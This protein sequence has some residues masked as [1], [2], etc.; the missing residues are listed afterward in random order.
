MPRTITQRVLRSRSLRGAVLL[1]PLLLLL[2]WIGGTEFNAYHVTRDRI[3]RQAHTAAANLAEDIASRLQTQ[4]T[5]LQFAA[6]ALL[7]PDA[8]PA[9][10]APHVM[11]TLR[12]FMA[13]HPSL[14][15]FNIQS[16][17]GNTLVWSSQAQS[18]QPISRASDFTPLRSNPDFLLGRDHFAARVGTHVLTM[19]YR[20]RGRGGATR[21]FVGTPYRLDQ[22]LQPP[23]PHATHPWVLSVRDTRDGSLLGVVD[24]GQVHLAQPASLAHRS[25]D[26]VSAPIAG[27]PLVV[28]ASWPA[29]LV[30]QTDARGA[31]LRW[32][33]ELG[34]LL[35][36]I[37][38]WA[39]IV[40]LLAQRERQVKLLYRMGDLQ[41][42]LAQVNQVAAESSD[43]DV[44]L[45]TVCDLAI[46]RGQLALALVAR[47]QES[48]LLTPVASAGK[49]AYL[50]GLVFSTDPGIPQGQ[51][52][53]GQVWRHGK[54]MFNTS[55]DTPALAPWR[56][57]AQALGL[58][59]SAALA[60]HHH[61]ARFGLL[62]LYRSDDVAFDTPMQSLLTELAEDVSRGLDRIAQRRQIN[63]LQRQY[64]ALMQTGDVLIHARNERDLLARLC[65]E[66]THDTAFHAVWIGRPDAQRQMQILAQVGEGTEGLADLDIRLPQDGQ[67]PLIVR[68]WLTQ[69]TVFNNDHQADPQLAPWQEFLQRHRW[70]SGLATPVR[71][72]GAIWAVL[73]FVS[74][75]RGVFDADTVTLCTRV[76][77]LLGR[78]LDALDLRHQLAQQQSDE[79][80][81]A[82]H[83]AL[84]GLPNRFALEQHLPLAIERARRRGTHLAVGMID[85][86]D[87]KPV[88][89]TFGH[90]AGDD[91]LRQLAARLRAQLRRP[92]LL[93]RLGGDEF[94]VI[95]EDLDA[96][97][98]MAQL[99]TAL[100]RLH[101]GVETPF[102]L[103]EGWQAT[104]G[105]T[106]GAALFPGDGQDA[107]SLLRQADAAMYVAKAHKGD[108]A[109]W[110]TLDAS[111]LQ[112]AAPDDGQPLDAYGPQ[113]QALLERHRAFW[114]ATTDRFVASWYADMAAH[115]EIEAIVQTL[116]PA[117]F[118]QLKAHQTQHLRF[119][120]DPGTAQQA[121]V[122]AA[123]H[124]GQ[125]HALTGVTASMLLTMMRAYQRILAEQW[126][127]SLSQP[128]QRSL[129]LHLL[130]SRLD[131]D[132]G[133]QL[134]AHT[135]T[136][137]VLLAPLTS[138]LPDNSTPW[139]QVVRDEISML[140]RL[141]GI[142]GV[143]LARPDA[144]GVLQLTHAVGTVPMDEVLA[145]LR[146]VELISTIDPQSARGQALMARAWRSA[147]VEQTGAVWREPG[148]QPWTQFHHAYG[149]RSLAAVPVCDAQ[150]RSQA[151]LAL[152]GTY[153]NQFAAAWM[154]QLLQGLRLRWQLLAS[155]AASPTFF[156]P[157]A[158]A[159][160]RRAALFDGG[161]H[162]WM[163]PIVDLRTGQ[164]AKVEALA[165][166]QM[167]GG[168]WLSPGEFL[169]LLGVPELRRLFQEGLRQSVQAVKSWEDDGLII[170]V[171]VNL[172]PSL[173]AADAWPGKVQT[174]LQDDALAPQRLTLELL[175]TETL[176]R[177]EQ[178]QTLMQL[179]ALGVKLAI[180]DLGSGYSSLTRLRQWPI[181]TLK[182]DQNLVRDVQR[183]PLR[184][185][186][187]VAAL[188]R[189]G[190]D[191]DT[192]VVVEGLETPGLIEMAQV[193]GA[194]YGQ[195]Y[196]LS[197]PMPSADLPAWIRNFQLGNARQALQTALGALTYHWDYMHRDDSARPTAL[198]A[199]P[200]TAYLERCGLTG[201]A[202][203]QAHRQIHAG[204]DVQRNSDVLLQG[205]RERVR[206]GE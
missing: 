126:L 147:E 77:D 165:R 191:L 192:E 57:R 59:A 193:L 115:P 82:R 120:L 40:R 135:D 164:A 81:R 90:A 187:M 16:A 34:S 130:Q 72:G 67:G 30:L 175:E 155:R 43:P 182:I 47:P 125:V 20:V 179:H 66:M 99:Q 113:A 93:T 201:S 97:T 52:P 50:E 189:L 74:A 102:D 70:A 122:S 37:L 170:D 76:G 200:L 127:Q 64:R 107:D 142:L 176:D 141:P 166:L 9:H 198:S 206:Q 143:T 96:E 35:L 87:F 195:G 118:A 160:Q 44:F 183:D 174:L 205:L 111:A 178:Q 36:L 51:G 145:A 100:D 89:D 112:A 185:L 106:L 23:S 136:L 95:L 38:A 149:V 159:H 56:Q 68:A 197:R 152:Y 144:Q 86:D 162:M 4:F 180:D 62:L 104:V 88:N 114:E 109:R 13:L 184:V 119:L 116:E 150:G 1:L 48:G 101:T 61:G 172:P 54:P 71:R 91:L 7:G 85:L 83:D 79:A 173:L 10:P 17:D 39:S 73:A 49:T 19:R 22:L 98:V 15:A 5:E 69:S 123:Q 26:A 41:D 58:H 65:Q 46:S 42:V 124:I 204:I 94:V 134:Q 3:R 203:E 80:Y 28:Q 11:Q 131:D 157:L 103:G 33:F 196:G 53:S 18:S 75:E 24:H 167:P 132:V 158:Q 140:A 2:A 108:R 202:L 171:S 137:S 153:P 161:L 27:F 168:T 139:A 55:F 78:G 199:C 169:P 8:D 138:P 148:L 146:Q 194:P 177:P 25:S 154:Q 31:K 105:M 14:Y 117:E 110:W 163:Q 6:V 156:V 181:S 129:L 29:A 190:R 12:R 21:Y 92:D 151:V 32:G 188:V 63:R 133:A 60:L 121:I 186:S 45:Q 128:A 84:T